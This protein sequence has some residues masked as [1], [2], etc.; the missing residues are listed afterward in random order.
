MIALLDGLR[1]RAGSTRRPQRGVFA[2]IVDSTARKSC[3]ARSTSRCAVSPS[4]STCR[5]RSSGGTPRRCERRSCSA[6][7]QRQVLELHDGVVQGLWPSPSSRSSSTGATNHAK[8]CSRPSRAP[9]R[10]SADPSTSCGDEGVPLRGADPRH[11][12]GLSDERTERYTNGDAAIGVLICD[13]NDGDADAARRDRRAD[14]PGLARRR[15]G[16]E[17]RTRRS[18]RRRGSSRTSS[19][20]TSRCPSAAASRRCPSSERSRLTRGSSSTPG[21][22]GEIVA[23]EVLALGAASYLEKGAHPDTIVATI[24]QTL[25]PG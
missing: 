22:A 18:S 13:D 5:A 8:R 19:C 6:T 3:R 9:A 10:S 12:A 15:R 23:D 17:R 14:A 20:S 1:R 25:A 24:E 16:V 21:F 2:Y 4:S 11:G 7:R